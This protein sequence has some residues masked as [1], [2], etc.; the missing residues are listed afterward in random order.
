MEQEIA[1]AAKSVP[2]PENH[3]SKD[4]VVPSMHSKQ[5]GVVQK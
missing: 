4:P 1:T 2:S 3:K 5:Q